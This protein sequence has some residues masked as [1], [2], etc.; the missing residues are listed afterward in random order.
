M[1]QTTRLLAHLSWLIPELLPLGAN[2]SMKPED[3]AAKKYDPARPRIK[4]TR[5]ERA[6]SL[7]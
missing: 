5:H 3:L 6:G 7:F 1:R 4:K 2:Q